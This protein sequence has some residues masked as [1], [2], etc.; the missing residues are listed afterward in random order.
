MPEPTLPRPA[1][2]LVILRNGNGGLEV[3][4]NRRPRHMTFMGGMTV[5]PG[6][7][8][9]PPD[10]DPRWEGLSKLD[11]ESAARLFPSTTGEEARRGGGEG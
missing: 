2:T 1:A 11:V 6:G 9:A 8:V 7:A 5:F 4:L 3:L 10:R